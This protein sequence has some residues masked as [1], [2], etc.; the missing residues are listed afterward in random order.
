MQHFPKFGLCNPE[1]IN[2]PGFSM[3]LFKRFLTCKFSQKGVELHGCGLKE[4]VAVKHSW[5]FDTWQWPKLWKWWGNAQNK[6]KQK[7]YG[8]FGP[9]K[10]ALFRLVFILIGFYRNHFVDG[11]GFLKIIDLLKINF[12]NKC[13]TFKKAAFFKNMKWMENYI[14]AEF[15]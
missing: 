5:T 12:T 10:L 2:R 14:F 8:P 3:Q 11:K 15:L 9:V 1:W 7:K 6:G 4:K 13:I